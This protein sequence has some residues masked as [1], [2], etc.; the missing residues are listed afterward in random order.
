MRIRSHLLVPA[1]AALAMFSTGVPANAGQDARPLSGTL[2]GV[3]NFEQ[4]LN[5]PIGLKTVSDAT[6]IFSHLGHT[7]MHSEHCTPT[8]DFITG[9]IMTL[10]AA[11]G[12]EITINYNGKA[13]FPAPGTTV[14]SITGD[15]LMVDGT[16]RFDGV[17]GGQLD[18]DW[19]TFNWTAA[20]LFPGFDPATGMPLPGPWYAT[21]QFGPMTIDY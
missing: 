3:V 17:T 13:P 16:G 15:A 18:G 11:N 1:I 10:T 5:C 4:D 7:T 9:G 20:V 14:I 19:D 12:D 2:S 6:G 8:G 21:W